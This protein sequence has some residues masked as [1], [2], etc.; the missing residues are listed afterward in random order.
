M[1]A[2][3]NMQQTEYDEIQTKLAALHEEILSNEAEIREL[4]TELTQIEGGFYV[5]MISIK[6][7]SLLSQMRSGPMTR[8]ASV[9]ENTRQ[10]VAAFADAVIQ[11]DIVD[12]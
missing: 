8:L 5:N 9:F 1:A 2:Y 3:I 6:I 4:I 10:A 12:Q 11:I 7:S